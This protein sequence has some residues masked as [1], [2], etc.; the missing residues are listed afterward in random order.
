[1]RELT[2]VRVER[3]YWNYLK[4]TSITFSV[5]CDPAISFLAMAAHIL[6]H[7]AEHPIYASAYLFILFIIVG[8][9]ESKGFKDLELNWIADIA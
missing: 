3:S 8:W 7:L 9:I 1:M 6:T 2:L 4:M 5:M